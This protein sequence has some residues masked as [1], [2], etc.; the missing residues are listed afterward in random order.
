MAVIELS[1]YCPTLA[2]ADAALEKRP[3]GKRGYLG[4]SGIG[5]CARKNYYRFYGVQ[6]SD[7]T[8][9]ALKNIADGFRTEELVI[10]RLRAVEGLTIIDVDPDTGKQI[11]VSD[12]DGHAM[13]HL[14]FEVF[15][16]LQAPKTPHVGEVKCI[17]DKAFKDLQRIIAKFGEKAALREWNEIYFAQGQMY[18]LYR[19]RTRHYCVVASA[20]GRD[21]LAIRTN[22]DR[23]LAEFYAER[24][25]QII[26]HGDALPPRIS[27]YRDF[28]K[29]RWCGFQD[30]CHD[31]LLPGRNC[32]TCV[33]SEPGENGSWQCKRFEMELDQETQDAGCPEQR[34]KQTFVGGTVTSVDDDKNTI[35]YEFENGEVWIDAGESN[36]PP[37]A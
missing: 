2:A 13:G 8:A 33:W 6:D 23:D 16:L 20:G 3:R 5:D 22:F 9:R 7:M 4:F 34:F 30:V 12:F 1:S 25:R 29:C 32:R 14:D 31:G 27:E 21:W 35:T 15:G 24:A 36:E 28:Y 37:A 19:G 26:Y 10:E 17:N 11:E 18:M